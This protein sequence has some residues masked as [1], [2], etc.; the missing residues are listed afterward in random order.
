MCLSV[1]LTLRPTDSRPV[2]LGVEHP[3]GAYDQIF[4]TCVTVTVLF[5]WGALSDERSGLSFYVLLVLASAVFLG[6]ESLGTWDHIL[7]SQIWDFPFRRL[8]RLAG[9]GWR[10]STS[11]PHGLWDYHAVCMS[12]LCTPTIN[13]WMP[14]LISMK[15][16]TYIMAHEHIST[17]YF[18]NP[19]HQSVWLYVYPTIVAKQRLSKH[20]PAV[21]NTD[22]SR[23]IVGRVVFYVVRFVSK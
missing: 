5:L 4:I 22:S 14:E 17:A 18:I 19:S 21:K 10:Y 23:R 12:V 16:G 2:C 9:S 3:S 13:F 11:P 1:S 15:L 20:V 6:S 7:L 8:L